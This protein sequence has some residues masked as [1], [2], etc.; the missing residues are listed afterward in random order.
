[1]NRKRIG[2]KIGIAILLII[3]LMVAFFYKDKFGPRT[4]LN[5][6]K[7]SGKNLAKANEQLADEVYWEGLEV[8]NEE[9]TILKI[10][11]EEINYEYMDNNELLSL[12]KSHNNFKWPIYLF[13]KR[14]YNIE[15]IYIYSMNN[16]GLIV[17]NASQ[18]NQ[19]LKNAA[20]EYSEESEKFEII[21]HQYKF[22]IE[23][24]ELLQLID[25]K[26]KQ[27][28]DVLDLSEYIELPEIL[29]NNDDLIKMKDE[30]NDYIN[31]EFKYQFGDNYEK[32]DKSLI[33]QWIIPNGL[34]IEF[35]KEKM[36]EYVITTLSNKY[37]T[38]GKPR[39]F[40]T[41]SGKTIKLSK[42]SYGWL[43]HRAN[44][45]EALIN[46]IKNKESKIIEPVYS[47]KAVSRGTSD[48]GNSYVEIDI[49]NQMVYVYSKG[50]LKVKTP[51]VTG[52]ISRGHNTPRNRVDPISYKTT[53]AV[54]RGPGYAAPVKYWMPFNGGVGLHD[55]DWRA[56]FGG[57]IY[58][59]NGSHGCI[60]LPPSIA[61]E[62]Y[63]LVFQGMPV[64]VH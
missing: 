37:D 22:N 14:D 19:E 28:E 52:N 48:I 51:T 27:A 2:I 62:V 26:I 17:E 4:F 20:V 43:I 57:N 55:A 41:T 9:E 58:K 45:V 10:T 30:A 13:S 47:Y 56:S 46:H 36:R 18:L 7:I 60:N 16:L 1:M 33:K 25:K 21:T 64:I 34:N 5:D 63:D 53:N 3:Y 61:K 24:D 40:K 44:T 11:P 31:L 59:T 6:Q 42:G 50:E 49:D 38:Y 23:K 54:L 29:D 39:N 8:K 12:I 35:E 15:P 32:I